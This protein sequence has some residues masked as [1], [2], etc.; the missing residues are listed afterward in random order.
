[1]KSR[2][3]SIQGE[4][5][6]HFLQDHYARKCLIHQF[7]ELALP[8]KLLSKKTKNANFKLKDESGSHELKQVICSSPKQYIITAHTPNSFPVASFEHCEVGKKIKGLPRHTHNQITFYDFVD[9]AMLVKKPKIIVHA[10]LRRVSLKI[11]MIKTKKKILSRTNSKRIFANVF[12]T[13]GSF[14][15]FPLNFKKRGLIE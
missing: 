12:R 15:S 9:V 8:F 3:D 2:Y 1:M 4:N 5:D 10:S 14:F 6:N 7:P 13:S 11:V